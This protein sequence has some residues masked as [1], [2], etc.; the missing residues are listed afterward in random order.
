MGGLSDTFWDSTYIPQ[1]F[2]IFTPR[3]VK[4]IITVGIYISLSFTNSVR[5][6]VYGRVFQLKY[7]HVHSLLVV[8]A[9]R[10]HPVACDC[11]LYTMVLF[12]FRRKIYERRKLYPNK[13]L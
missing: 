5:V 13:L 8:Y 7:H 1:A 6:S 2:V 4:I 10:A 3:L 12:Y 11:Y 9:V